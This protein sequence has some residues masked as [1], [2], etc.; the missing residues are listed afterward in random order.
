MLL[1]HLQGLVIAGMPSSGAEDE[2][3]LVG[4]CILHV[5][6]HSAAALGELRTSYRVARSHHVLR[7]FT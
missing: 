6:E 7:K 1:N 4:C 3:G 2:W 5:L